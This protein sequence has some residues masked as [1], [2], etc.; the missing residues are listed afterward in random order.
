MRRAGRSWDRQLMPPSRRLAAG[1]PRA[2]NP[3]AIL[4]CLAGLCGIMAVG[5]FRCNGN[6]ELAYARDAGRA[7]PG[8]SIR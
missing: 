2:A 5:M 7:I 8:R 1:R 3:P 6:V 4:P